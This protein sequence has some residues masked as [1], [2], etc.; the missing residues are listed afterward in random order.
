MVKTATINR[1][2]MRVR[3]LTTLAA[4]RLRIRGSFGWLTDSQRAQFDSNEY[5]IVREPKNRHDPNAIAIYGRER[6]V[7]YVS[8]AKSA[9]LAPLLDELDDCDGFIVK[10]AP[11]DE[12]SIRMWINLPSVPEIRSYVK[13]SRLPTGK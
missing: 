1:S 10:G 6:K 13:R 7:G 11:T 5:V 9:L 8:A 12:A 3:D 2:T 4:H